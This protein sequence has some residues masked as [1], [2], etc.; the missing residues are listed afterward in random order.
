[1]HG[2][3]GLPYDTSATRRLAV[4]LDVA[5]RVVRVAAVAVA[6]A[7]AEPPGPRGGRRVRPRSGRRVVA[8][9]VDDVVAIAAWAPLGGLA[10]LATAMAPW[11]TD[12]RAARRTCLALAAGATA[13]AVGYETAAGRAGAGLGKT[14]CGLRVVDATSG[15]RL[16][17]GR[18]L[19]RGILVA[20]PHPV[21]VA[22]TG[23]AAWGTRTDA[24]PF[25]TALGASLAWRGLLAL[26]LHD[27]LVGSAV[28]D[29]SG[30]R[31]HP[32]S[33]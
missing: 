11:A 12:E 22:G 5:S 21:A 16:P 18:A 23:V 27:R 26:G 9:G 4:A 7:A 6:V 19:A 10:L 30:G 2:D 31:R 15:G 1:M 25:V 28:V 14:A 13:T 24:T 20:G 33:S 3:R 8:R 17:L 32:R 29:V